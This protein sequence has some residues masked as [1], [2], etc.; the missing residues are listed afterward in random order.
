MDRLNIR[1]CALVAAV[2][3]LAVLNASAVSAQVGATRTGWNDLSPQVQTWLVT[4]TNNVIALRT[5]VATL[6]S[7]VATL[8]ASL[9]AAEAT[10]S[11]HTTA[12]GTNTTAIGGNTSSITTNASDIDGLEASDVPGLGTYLR[13]GTHNSKPAVIFEDANVL[14]LDGTGSTVT[15]PTTGLGN[16]IVGYDESSTD[17]I[18][19]KTGSHNLVVGRYHTYSSYGGLVAGNDNN[20]TGASASVSGGA[21]NTASGLWSSVSGGS[22]NTASESS[23]S[24]SGGYLNTASGNSSSVSGGTGNTASVAWRRTTIRAMSTTIRKTTNAWCVCVK[25]KSERL[26]RRYHRWR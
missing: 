13:I 24:V 21:S 5:E 17:P 20:V 4:Q 16:L 22:G 8:Q 12:I 15:D 3:V 7:T 10:I 19:I 11:G 25:R 6:T 26:P 9:A 1:H 14:V 23:S 18:D 2:G